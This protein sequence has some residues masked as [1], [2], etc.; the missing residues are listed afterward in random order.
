ME[1]PTVPLQSAARWR[2]IDPHAI[3]GERDLVERAGTLHFFE[4]AQS[5]LPACP[6]LNGR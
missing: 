3:R 2:G 6:G 4:D 1:L 5:A